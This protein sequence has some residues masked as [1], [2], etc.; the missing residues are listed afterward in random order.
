MTKFRAAYLAEDW[1]DLTRHDLLSMTQGHLPFWHWAVR[2]QSINSLLSNTNSHLDNDQLRHHLEVG[3]DAK[4]A[5]KCRNE[6]SSKVTVFRLWLLEIKHVDDMMNGE[7]RERD[8]EVAAKAQREASRRSHGL[9]EPSQHANSLNYLNSYQNHMN[10]Y[11]TAGASSSAAPRVTLPKLTD[12]NKTLLADNDGC[13]NFCCFWVG[14]HSSACPYGFPDPATYKPLTARDAATANPENKKQNRDRKKVTAVAARAADSS[15]SK[16]GKAL[17]IAMVMGMSTNP[18]AYMPAN[19]S[20]I[21]EGAGSESDGSVVS[22]SILAVLAAATSSNQAVPAVPLSGPEGATLT[23]SAEPS[24]RPKGTS[25][26]L[27]S[28]PHLYW[29]CAVHG[30]RDTLPVSFYAL[31]DHGSH[32]VLIREEFAISLGLRCRPLHT[33]ETVKLAM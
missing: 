6:K 3:M 2:V 26:P 33:P 7:K 29:H 24:S 11:S 18:V 19:V 31:I 20:N 30:K 16:N 13:Y 32:A 28:L 8:F 27:F 21:I 15:D 23:P 22:H 17:P 9:S 1:E 12:N 14:H 25:L 10:N 5:N 4:L